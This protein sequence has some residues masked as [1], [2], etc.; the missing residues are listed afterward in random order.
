[1]SRQPP[2]I[3]VFIAQTPA[4]NM[5]ATM[6]ALVRDPLSFLLT[7][8]AFRATRAAAWTIAEGVHQFVPWDTIAE[9][10]ESGWSGG[11]PTKYVIQAQGWYRARGFISLSGTGAAG[12]S[13]VPELAVNGASHTGISGGGGWEGVYGPAP[14]GTTTQPKGKNGVWE[15]Y[16]N[17]GDY[18][19]MDLFYTT[20]S[21]I[22]STDS[23]SGWQPSIEIVWTGA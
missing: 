14:T 3:P 10:T 11:D 16:G 13:M 2:S 23:T 21:A 19:Q 17:P 1:M 22:T 7:K 20:E 12:L 4:A 6:N 18:V 9:D 15:F 5:A 8:P